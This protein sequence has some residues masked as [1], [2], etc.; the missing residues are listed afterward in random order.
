[1][2]GALTLTASLLG[3]AALLFGG[4]AT[5]PAAV[6]A[7]PPVK[8]YSAAQEKALGAAVAALP[9]DS[10]LVGAMADYGAERAALRACAKAST[11]F[12]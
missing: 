7:C 8:A 9:P 6:P 11:S 5:H 1:M 3:Y 2:R 4:C 10:P 12:R